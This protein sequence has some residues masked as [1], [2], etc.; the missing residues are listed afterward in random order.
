[1]VSHREAWLQ[2]IRNRDE[3]GRRS[4]WLGD[5]RA[6]ERLIIHSRASRQGMTEKSRAE[7]RVL[8]ARA[9]VARQL[10]RGEKLVELAHAVVRVRI[11]R[12]FRS[13]I[14]RQTRQA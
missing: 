5:P 12:I 8:I 4:R 9:D 13:E 10:I 14:R 11:G 7:V 3:R 1:V 2:R 6:Y